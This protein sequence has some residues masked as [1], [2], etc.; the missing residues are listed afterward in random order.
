MAQEVSYSLPCSLFT[1]RLNRNIRTVPVLFK[2]RLVQQIKEKYQGKK[3][4]NLTYAASA[5]GRTRR[6]D[7][8]ASTCALQNSRKL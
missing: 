3:I 2:Y 5:F 7:R 6:Y 4:L 1:K 8:P